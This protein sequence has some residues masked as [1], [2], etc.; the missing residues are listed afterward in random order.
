MAGGATADPDD[1]AWVVEEGRLTISSV[2]SAP[3]A[4]DSSVVVPAIS[5]M[6]A[7]PATEGVATLKLIVRGA[8]P[9]LDT[10]VMTGLRS[11]GSAVSMS[12]PP[13]SSPSVSWALFVEK[14]S[15]S[16]LVDM[17]AIVFLVVYLIK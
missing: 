8:I 13:A 2:M 6:V 12:V 16:G 10:R 4:F 14:Y 3:S 11:R 9:G 1:R 17:V 5:S 7:A 15:S